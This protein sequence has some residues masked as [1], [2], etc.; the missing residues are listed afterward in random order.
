MTLLPQVAT[1]QPTPGHPTHKSFLKI[2]TSN[3]PTSSKH[4]NAPQVTLPHHTSSHPCQVTHITPHHLSSP[5][6]SPPL[7]Y[8]DTGQNGPHLQQ[9]KLLL[10][11]PGVTLLPQNF[12]AGVTLLPQVITAGLSHHINPSQVTQSLKRSRPQ[13]TPCHSTSS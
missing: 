1:P 4:A 6:V 11:R 7:K 9:I 8:F 13:V 10:L 12:T 3:H 2:L 5:Q